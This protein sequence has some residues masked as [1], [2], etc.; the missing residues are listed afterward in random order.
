MTSLLIILLSSYLIMLVLLIWGFTRATQRPEPAPGV[1]PGL[2]VIIPCRNEETNLPEL[3]QSLLRQQFPAD[4]MEIILVYD[5]SKDHTLQLMESFSESD[6]RVRAITLPDRKTGKKAALEEGIKT[7][8]FSVIVTTDADCIHENGWLAAIGR[9]MTQPDISMVVGMVRVASSGGFFQ[10]LQS[11]E[12]ASLTGSAIAALGWR[13]PLMCNGASLAFRKEV[14]GKVGGYE[15]DRHLASGDDEFLMRKVAALN[16]GTIVPMTSS[17]S[18]VE[19]RPQA[20][21]SLFVQQRIRWA[22][23]WK[24]NHDPVARTTALLVAAAH[25]AFLAS[26]V[27]ILIHPVSILMYLTGA[28]TLAEGYFFTMVSKRLAQPFDV[29]SFLMWQLIYPFYVLIIGAASLTLSW[30]WKGRNYAQ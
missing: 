8:K 25:L 7:A 24:H 11:L 10:R 4:R 21:W 12:F 1:V 5:H 14:F 18:V 27:V 6:R 30:N 29:V 15:G 28:K 20:T 2:S 22:S 19:T 17:G 9:L 23:K 13:R 26:I 3:I 16:H